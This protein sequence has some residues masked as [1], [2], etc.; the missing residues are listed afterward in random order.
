MLGFTNL[1]NYT[2][3]SKQKNDYLL[4]EINFSETIDQHREILFSLL[5]CYGGNFSPI[6]FCI[7]DNLWY[8]CIHK[9]L[10][11]SSHFSR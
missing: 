10:G 7:G 11:P 4:L 9:I 1:G 2:S 6:F 3:F 8:Y 5:N